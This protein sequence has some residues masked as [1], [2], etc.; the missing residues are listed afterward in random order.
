MGRTFRAKTLTISIDRPTAEVYAFAAEVANLPRWA[1]SFVRSVRKTPE[2]WVAETTEGSMGF[3]FTPK[4]ALGV[5]DQIVRPAPG[6]ENSIPIRVVQNGDGA[7]I[8]FTL[9]QFP[10]M[11]DEKFARDLGMV[12]RD[13][14]TLKLV[15]ETNTDAQ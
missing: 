6:I 3:E 12:A 14:Q 5:L 11:P 8:T 1:T 4:N 7:E 10:G 9:I 13:L 2:G 15:L